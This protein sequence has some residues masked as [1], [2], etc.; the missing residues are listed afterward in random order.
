[1]SFYSKYFEAQQAF[2]QNNYQLKEWGNFTPKS[3]DR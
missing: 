2:T 3:A 1:M